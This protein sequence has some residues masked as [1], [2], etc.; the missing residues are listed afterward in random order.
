MRILAL[1]ILCLTLTWAA[2]GARPGRGDRTAPTAPTSRP[3]SRP[4]TAPTSRPTS[5]P[6]AAPTAR[7]TG[8]NLSPQQQQNVV[9]LQSDLMSLKGDSQVT[10]EQK[11]K[12]AADLNTLAQGTVRPSQESVDKLA[13]DL[14][15]SMA[16]SSISQAEAYKPRT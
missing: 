2:A 3:A 16:D 1:C 10:Q 8:E 5:R 12:L 13:G 14:A 4:T 15:D 9:K 7:P 11:Q 6:T